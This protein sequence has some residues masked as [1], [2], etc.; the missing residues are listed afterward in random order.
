[1][2]HDSRDNSS[3]SLDDQNLNASVSFVKAH[4][5]PSSRR[6]LTSTSSQTLFLLMNR[7]NYGEMEGQRGYREET[8]Q[9]PAEDRGTWS[10]LTS[11]VALRP[12]Q[13]V[14]LKLCALQ[15]DLSPGDGWH[16]AD[17]QR[18]ALSGNSPAGKRCRS[19]GEFNMFT[20]GLGL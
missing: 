11:T 12:S 19:L 8:G 1:M 15:G 10:N 2:I 18:K 14:Y 4:I 9:S 20:L 16:S 13:V 5:P 7:R 6:S 17:G 3:T